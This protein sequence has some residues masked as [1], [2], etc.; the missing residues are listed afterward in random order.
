[1][2]RGRRRNP[3]AGMIRTG[4]GERALADRGCRC[5]RRAEGDGGWTGFCAGARRAGGTVRRIN[6]RR[7]PRRAPAADFNAV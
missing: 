4:G 3:W 5:R 2:V 7:P 6:G 1:L